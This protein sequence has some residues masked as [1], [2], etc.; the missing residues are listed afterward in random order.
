MAWEKHPTNPTKEDVFRP[1]GAN[2][3]GNREMCTM[4]KVFPRVMSRCSGITKSPCFPPDVVHTPV[5]GLRYVYVDATIEVATPTVR[6]TKNF[7]THLTNL[8][9]HTMW[10]GNLDRLVAALQYVVICRAGNSGPWVEE[11][12][13]VA[14][15]EE[16]QRDV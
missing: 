6:G 9:I 7:C 11:S 2:D 8:A 13:R 5:T 12:P 15:L 14:F 10:L 16:L 4:W 3:S 1:R